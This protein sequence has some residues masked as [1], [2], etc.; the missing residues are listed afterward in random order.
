MLLICGDVIRPG[1]AWLLA[2]RA[3]SPGGRAGPHPRPGRVRRAVRACEAAPVNLTRELRCTGSPRSW[4]PRAAWSATSPSV[5]AWSCRSGRLLRAG[6]QQDALLP[7]AARGRNARAG[8]PPTSGCS[9]AGSSPEQ[10]IDRYDLDCRP[11]RDL[12]VDYLRERQPADF[13]TLRRWPTPGPAVLERPGTASSGDRL[14]GLSAGGRRLETAD[15]QKPPARAAGRPDPRDRGGNAL[16]KVRA[17]Y[18]DIAQWAAED[19][20]RW[21][22]WAAPARSGRRDPARGRAARRKSRMDQRTRE[23]L[24]MLPALVG[25][26]RPA[27]PQ[28][29]ARRRPAAGPG[30]CSPPA[31]GPC[32]GRSGRRTPPDL[33]R[34]PR[35]RPAPRP[36]PRRRKRVLGL[37]RGGSPPPHR[38]PDRGTDRAVPPQPGPVPAARH[39]RADP[40]AADRPVQDR[41]GTA[42]GLT[43]SSPTCCPHHHPGPRRTAGFRW[44]SLRRQ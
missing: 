14:A 20:A 30:G 26:R 27:A 6:P 21:A 41:R 17:F 3:P 7:A 29:P 5:T 2:A 19:P 44:S 42:P 43:P 31:G 15:H 16:V 1:L 25:R 10:L 38:H 28:P 39:R 24:P 40:A 36:D 22:P 12:L 32:A 37:G 9:S 33:G 34:R 18:L 23:R 35:Q 8:A 13:S 11:V 4:P